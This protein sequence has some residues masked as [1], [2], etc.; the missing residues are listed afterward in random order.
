[1]RLLSVGALRSKMA[2][3][4]VRFTVSVGPCLCG[5]LSVSGPVCRALSLSGPVCVWPCLSGPVCVGPCLCR[6]MSV[7]GPVCVGYRAPGA[8]F[9]FRTTVTWPE[10]HEQIL[11]NQ[12]CVAELAAGYK[13]WE[14]AGSQCGGLR[15]QSNKCCWCT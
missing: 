13:T 8:H 15:E 12:K 10:P 3:H 7:S 14:I 11:A 5:A 9:S 1:V 2:E 4:H 6:A